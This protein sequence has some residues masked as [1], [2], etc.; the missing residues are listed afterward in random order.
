MIDWREDLR[1]CS[2]IMNT[3]LKLNIPVSN[4]QNQKLLNLLLKKKPMPSK[5][6][7][8]NKISGS[9]FEFKF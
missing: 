5:K 4:A 8:T 6:S 7:P 9:R 1:A 3:S 2:E